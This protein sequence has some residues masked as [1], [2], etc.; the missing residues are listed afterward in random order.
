MKIVLVGSYPP[1]KM[2]LNEYNWHLAQ[3]LKRD[4]SI[5]LKVLADI[6]PERLKAQEVKEPFVERCWKYNCW[7]N[8]WKILR[9]IQKEKPDC[10]WFD[11]LFSTFGDKNVLAF[12]GLFSPWLSRLAGFYTI[13]TL[14]HLAEFIDF[15]D[16]KFKEISNVEKLATMLATK[17]ILRADAVF[18]TLNKYARLLRDKYRA[19]NAH[20]ILHGFF[21]SNDP[22]LAPLNTKNIL[23]FGKFGSYKKIDFMI[24]V[25]QALREEIPGVTLTV[26]GRSHPTYPGYIEDA[27][28]RYHDVPG[29][30]FTGY[31]KENELG[32]I[33]R[34]SDVLALPYSSTTGVSGVAHIACAYGLPIV[35]SDLPDILSMVQEEGISLMTFPAGDKHAAVALFKRMLEDANLMKEMGRRNCLIA[36][37]SS[38]A[39]I[40]D[41]YKA[42]IKN[43]SR[44]L[45]G[46]TAADHGS[47]RS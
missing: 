35:A 15:Q 37:L 33:F 40:V 22:E 32:H 44:R 41:Q 26:A 43:F 30:I 31:L 18:V 42:F 25:F 45:N 34:H 24:E 14:H 39:M 11:L 1:S 38:I 6:L 27:I 19:K 12:L 16:T 9:A 23:L 2:G 10:I 28:A 47:D 3:E 21:T 17:M 7:F 20:R 13:V 29:L 5:E 46:K 36:Q 4:P 8:F